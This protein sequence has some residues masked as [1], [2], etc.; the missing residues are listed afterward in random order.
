MG[1]K[2][3]DIPE[4]PKISLNDEIKPMRENIPVGRLGVAYNRDVPQ[5]FAKKVTRGDPPENAV[6]YYNKFEGYAISN[7]ILEQLRLH[8]VGI[9][10]TLE[11]DTGLVLEHTIED[12]K[13]QVDNGVYGDDEQYCASE[14][15]AEYRW[16]GLGEELFTNESFWSKQ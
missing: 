10:F 3:Y 13:H 11:E 7:D 1:W 14:H 15:D 12:F 4:E 6:H 9:I 8:D 5:V 16:E 2:E